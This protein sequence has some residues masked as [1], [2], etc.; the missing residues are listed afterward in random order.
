MSGAA[1]CRAN[2]VVCSSPAAISARH[3]DL[4]GPLPR[5]DR[6]GF[7][8]AGQVLV[9]QSVKAVALPVEFFLERD[10]PFPDRRPFV[11]AD[12]ERV[13]D[14]VAGHDAAGF[15][16]VEQAVGGMVVEM[17]GEVVEFAS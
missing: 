3:H 9:D 2:Q 5:P 14:A 13:A 17:L 15:P 11:L 6:R 1:S 4:E 8:A 12:P 7:L 10:H 16:A